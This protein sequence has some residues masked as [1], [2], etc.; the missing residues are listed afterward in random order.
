MDRLALAAIELGAT[1]PAAVQTGRL[2]SLL[3][4]FADSIGP[5]KRRDD[6]IALLNRSHIGADGLDD[7]DELVAH[8]VPGL[9]CRH[10]VVRPEITAA[11]ARSCYTNQGIC[12]L[13]DFGA[14]NGLDAHIVHA[15]HQSRF[16][17]DSFSPRL[18]AGYLPYCSSVTCSI[19]ST[20]LASSISAIAMCVIAVVGD[21]PCQC[22]SPGSN[23]TMSPARI[24]SI[25]PPSR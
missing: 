24:S 1:P 21:A 8:A 13:G 16:A 2:Q 15:V 3:A 19:H 4:E 23:P 10:R 20:T 11:N 12:R 14:G 18:L 6:Q 5:R 7:S 25:G 17:F 9:A 22:R